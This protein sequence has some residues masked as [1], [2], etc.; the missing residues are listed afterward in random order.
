MTVN[1][2]IIFC[3][4]NF[5]KK[6][7]EKKNEKNKPNSTMIPQPELFFGRF[8]RVP[9]RTLGI[10]LSLLVSNEQNMVNAVKERTLGRK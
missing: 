5:S 10:N 8:G 1:F 7:S 9:K 4:L 2:K 6:T 3:N